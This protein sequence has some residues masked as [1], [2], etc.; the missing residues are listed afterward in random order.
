MIKSLDAAINLLQVSVE[1]IRRHGGRVTFFLLPV[2]EDDLPM[3]AAKIAYA[4]GEAYNNPSE[5][6]WWIGMHAPPQG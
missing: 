3:V 1:T 2:G 6:V 4:Q 5:D